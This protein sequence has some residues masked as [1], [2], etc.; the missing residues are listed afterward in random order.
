M[1]SSVR[2]YYAPADYE[3][4][5]PGHWRGQTAVVFDILRATSTIVTALAGGYHSARCFRAVAD[6]RHY[7]ADHARVALAGERD[8]MPPAGF[9][10]GNSPREFRHKPASYDSLALTTTNGTRAIEAVS[11]ARRV[12]IAS[13]LNLGAV[14]DFLRRE[15]AAPLALVCAGS[16]EDFSL[17]DAI[18]AGALLEA[19]NLSHPLTSLYAANRDDLPRVFRAAKNGAHLLELGLAADI[20]WCLQRDI[21]PVLPLLV[22]GAVL[23]RRA[24]SR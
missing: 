23:L 6:A 14:A 11:G 8:G 3:G 13:L 1:F 17:E 4:P 12:V 16:G 19:L 7:A 2:V 18:A 9:Q 21:Y 24:R 20:D 5:P 15:P 22:N 10:F